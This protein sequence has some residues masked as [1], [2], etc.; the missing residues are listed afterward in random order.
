[1]LI[2]ILIPLGIVF[3]GTLFLLPSAVVFAVAYPVVGVWALVPAVLTLPVGGWIVWWW[4][5]RVPASTAQT[6]G[7]AGASGV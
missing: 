3:Y 4:V 5:N 1:M 7:I 2:A 6:A